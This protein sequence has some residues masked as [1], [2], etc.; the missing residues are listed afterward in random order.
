MAGKGKSAVRKSARA[1]TAT[2]ALDVDYSQFPD[3]AKGRAMA[4]QAAR[5]ARDEKTEKKGGSDEPFVVE[6][7][8]E[9]A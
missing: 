4:R 1:V 5:R 3:T 9:T 6:E 7:P 8:T 2:A